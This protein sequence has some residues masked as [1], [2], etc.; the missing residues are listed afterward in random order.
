MK[1]DKWFEGRDRKFVTVAELESKGSWFD[2]FWL[3]TWKK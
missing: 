1:T 3:E 2:N